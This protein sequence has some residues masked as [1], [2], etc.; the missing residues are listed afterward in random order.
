LH[1]RGKEIRSGSGTRG[2]ILGDQ[3]AHR[4]PRELVEQ[5]QHSLPNGAA[6][7]FE[8]DIDPVRIGSCELASEPLFP[9]NGI[10]FWWCPKDTS[11][12]KEAAAQPDIPTT[13]SA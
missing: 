10:E 5:G 12:L 6:D 13:I 8:I 9:G 11:P 2:V 4:H 1:G 3:P 7:I